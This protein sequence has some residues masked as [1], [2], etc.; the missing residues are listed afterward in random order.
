MAKKSKNHYSKAYQALFTPLAD[1]VINMLKR[2][3]TLILITTFCASYAMDSAQPGNQSNDQANNTS[4]NKTPAAI[5]DLSQIDVNGVFKVLVAYPSGRQYLLVIRSGEISKEEGISSYIGVR[6]ITTSNL[7]TNSHQ[8]IFYKPIKDFLYSDTSSLHI[9]TR[10]IAHIERFLSQE[11][12]S[13]KVTEDIENTRGND[14]FLLKNILENDTNS[15]IVTNINLNNLLDVLEHTHT[16]WPPKK[17]SSWVDK[18]SGYSVVKL[19]L[20]MR[21]A[22]NSNDN[23]K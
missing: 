5:P 15:P 17:L 16:D 2:I 10:G 22:T 20:E 6:Y 7:Y 12:P 3:L 18:R 11:T 8:T 14:L 21:K 19:A 4:S 13:K 9:L 23:E 1:E